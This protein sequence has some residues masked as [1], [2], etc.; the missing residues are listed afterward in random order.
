MKGFSLYQK[1]ALTIILLGLLPMAVLATFIANKMIKDYSLALRG[2]YEQAAGYVESSID[3]T[4]DGYNTISKM[5]YFYNF[6]ATG[7]QNSY[8]SF[9]HFRQ[10]LYGEAYDPAT[11][12]EDRERDMGNFLQ[13]LQSVDSY[14]SSVHVI[15]QDSRQEKVSFH[16]S[17]Y[18]T[19]FLDSELFEKT[20]AYEE[21]DKTG[22]NLILLPPHM[23]TYF[24][25][26][27]EMVFTVARNYFDLRGPVGNTPYVGTIFIDIDLKKIE[28]IFRSVE[29][30]GNEVIYVV[31]EDNDCFYSNAEE[32]IG[33][34]IGETLQALE[35]Q[36]DR[37]VIRT[38]GN[39]YGLSVVVSLDTGT[40]FGDIRRMQQTM[41]VFVG[42]SVLAL[43]VGSFYFSKRLTRPIHEM[44]EQ[45]SM[46]ETGNFDIELPIRSRDEIGV[47]SERFNQMSS[48]L[49]T[50][51]NQSYVAQ[52]KQ[53][54]AELT[55]LKSQIYPHFLYNTLE[56]IR[57]TALEDEGGKQVPEMIEALSG[58]I[59]Y[60]IGPMQDMVPLEKEIDHINKYV[61]LLNC[62]IGSKI[63]LLVNAQGGL[64]VQVPKL[65]LQPIVENAY[66]HGIKPKKGKGRIMVETAVQGEQF[67]ISVMDNGIGMDEEALAKI[68]KLFESDDPGIKNEYNWQSIGLKN[69]H[70]RIRFLYGEAYGIRITSTQA[71][72]TMVRILLPLK[73]ITEKDM[74]T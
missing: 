60:L 32:L 5:P 47:L 39:H 29:F 62:R 63:Q 6:N 74:D 21:L 10:I 35:A 67:E 44:M 22:K 41:Y 61:Y 18:N 69:V 52:I 28:G 9:D 31:N 34:N 26:T 49:K 56:I 14:I 1:F 33:Q 73:Q 65:I 24:Y 58:Q 13:Y 4:L 64:K 57:M 45:M 50:Y 51:I 7:A 15:A 48:A 55:A 42:I 25:G 11:M 46:V 38:K 16:Y 37:F 3:A 43:F 8:L 12:K 23:T 72:G 17:V 54:E 71:V 70:D 30:T 53:N 66:V 2:Q 20:V 59:H 68:T 27:P 40:A 36:E 19:F